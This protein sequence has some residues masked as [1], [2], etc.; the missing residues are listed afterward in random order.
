MNP[1]Y[2]IAWVT[3]AIFILISIVAHGPSTYRFAI[4]FLAP[5]LWGLLAGIVNTPA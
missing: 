5:M 2:L 4:I 3:T 1:F